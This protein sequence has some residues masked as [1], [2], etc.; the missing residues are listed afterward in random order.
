MPDDGLEIGIISAPFPTIR[1][2]MFVLFALGASSS[3]GCRDDPD[4]P[5]IIWEGEHIRFGTDADT[6]ICAGT[7]PYLDGVTGH[8]AEVLQ[9]PG[10]KVDYYWLPDGVGEFCDDMDDLRGCVAS[11]A[12][13]FSTLAVHQHEL[14][15]ALRYP[16]RLYLPLE[17]GLAEAYGDDWSRL[18]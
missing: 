2:G 9:Q 18:R 12:E 14:V 3:A 13:V 16:Q 4:R 8:L 1:I 17:E 10:V 5:P 7:L 15:H 6:E 11:E